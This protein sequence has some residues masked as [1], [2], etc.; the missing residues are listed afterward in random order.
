MHHVTK[1]IQ[2]KNTIQSMNQVL[3]PAHVDE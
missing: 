3:E 1:F 2:R